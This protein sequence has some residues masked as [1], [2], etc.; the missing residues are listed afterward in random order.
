[1]NKKRNLK[2][3][4]D[5]QQDPINFISRQFYNRSI[6]QMLTCM[7]LSAVVLMPFLILVIKI[8]ASYSSLYKGERRTNKRDGLP[9]QCFSMDEEVILS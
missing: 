6:A 2:Y 4:F 9:C 3:S 5:F 1:M 8:M 7:Q